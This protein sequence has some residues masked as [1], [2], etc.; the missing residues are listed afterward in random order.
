M[1]LL[2]WGTGFETHD[3]NVRAVREDSALHPLT[4][5]A[6]MGRVIPD[7]VLPIVE[8]AGG[9][10]QFTLSGGGT[11]AYAVRVNGFT[12]SECPAIE[13]RAGGGWET[14]G[15]AS[16]THGDDGYTVFY[17]P[18]TGLYDFSFVVEMEG[19]IAQEYRVG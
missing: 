19:G 14:V 13:R 17:N 5:T 3:A 9:Q 7:A 1:I 8:S 12:Q 6:S 11:T 16:S 4:V 10:A 18:E 2:P 15:L